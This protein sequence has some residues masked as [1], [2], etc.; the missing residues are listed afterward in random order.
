MNDPN[1]GGGMHTLLI[2]M[3]FVYLHNYR[4]GGSHRDM[5]GIVSLSSTTLCCSSSYEVVL[6]SIAKQL[7]P[8]Q[9]HMALTETEVIV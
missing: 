2:I 8:Q 7:L 3:Q 6:L 4:G 9:P 5:S 1:A